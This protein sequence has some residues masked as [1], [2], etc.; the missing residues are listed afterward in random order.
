MASSE[1]SSPTTVI[2][3]YLNEPEK[4]NFDLKSYLMMM[5]KSFMKDINSSLKEIQE[6]SGKRLET[7]KE[8]T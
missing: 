5:I 4:Q 3:G 7:F 8:E 6:N 2:P 1:S